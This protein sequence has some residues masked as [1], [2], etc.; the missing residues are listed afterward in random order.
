MGRLVILRIAD[1]FS[2]LPGPRF[3]KE[4]PNSAE[5]FREELLIPRFKEADSND[6]ILLVDL[7]GVIGYATSF[8]EDSFGSLAREFGIECVL[9]RLSFKSTDEP[10]LED[11]IRRYIRESKTGA[12]VR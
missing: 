12:R 2:L 7:D 11:D 10:Y 1:E 5:Q 4:G 9:S 8:L 6:Q 3:R